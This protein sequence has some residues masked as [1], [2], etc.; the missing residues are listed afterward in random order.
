[1]AKKGNDK[2]LK[3]PDI[4]GLELDIAGDV[5]NDN[6]IKYEIQDKKIIT[7]FRDKN[8]VGKTIPKRNTIITSNDVVKIYPSKFKIGP[9]LILLLIIGLG[10]FYALNNRRITPFLFGS[11]YIEQSNEDWNKSTIVYVKDDAHFND[12]KID[13]YKY[14]ISR[15]RVSTTCD[16]KDTYTKSIEISESGTWFVWF[17]GV[18]EDGDE[19]ALSNR[20]KV[21]VDNESPI[22]TTIDKTISTRSIEVK[23]DAKDSLSGIN[24]Y[25]YSIDNQ[26]YIES[27][28][29][30]TFT[31]L[32]ENKTYNIKIRVIDKANNYTDA[33]LT[34]STSSTNRSNTDTTTTINRIVPQISMLNVRSIIT[35]GDKYNLPTTITPSKYQDNTK[36]YANDKEIANTSELSVGEYKIKCISTIDTLSITSYKDV[37]VKVEDGKDTVL[38]NYARLNLSY[39]KNATKYM[40]RFETDDVR[41]DDDDWKYYTGPLYISKDK[42]DKVII[43]YE[44]NGEHIVSDDNMFIDIRPDKYVLSENE[45]TW[46]NIIH[47]NA[48]DEI[49]Y[50]INGSSYIRYTD[51][52]KVKG[53]ATI[54]AYIK[55]INKV[56]D[57][58]A[59]KIVEE[60]SI[61][62]DSVYIEKSYSNVG[63]KNNTDVSIS[64]EDLPNTLATNKTYSIPSSYSYGVHG[65]NTLVCTYDNNIVNNTSDLKPGEYNIVC[66]ITALD[67]ET[68]IASKYVRVEYD[69]YKYDLDNI[70]SIIK[71]G[72]SYKLD[73]TCDISN[74]NELGLGKHT[75]KCNNISKDIEVVKELKT[76]IDLNNIPDKI[77]V[78]S[79]YE[80]PSHYYGNN[81]KFIK[82]LDEN[83]N[84][85]FNTSTLSIGKH[86]L[87][88]IIK[89]EDNVKIASKK[90]EVIKPKYNVDKSK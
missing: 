9:L 82:C 55:K 86:T 20:L 44:L 67:G 43:K 73:K 66:T 78:G 62:Y 12:N 70:P 75:I 74:T 28:K 2:Q 41:L 59:N 51:S 29:S 27:N 24:K 21:T 54:K 6:D 35:E 46:V 88:C 18:A 57:A 4:L 19:S 16:F 30:Y 15:S 38:G 36:C 90:I 37:T 39:P 33:S 40:Y 17:K 22:I 26:E 31:S 14:C 3:M 45:E 32:E 69:N 81:I 5:L 83:N 60:E 87:M 71:I 25:L 63:D 48:E 79:L 47:F 65:I 53:N 8:C 49:Y 85:I 1:M 56:Y 7:F 68:K 50:S 80:L 76:F 89:D 52:F 58:E 10:I 11:P 13:Y 23:V 34:L 42:I 64:L 61:A 72:D 77:T 84:L